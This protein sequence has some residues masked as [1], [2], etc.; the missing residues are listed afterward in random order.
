MAISTQILSLYYWLHVLIILLKRLLTWKLSF[1]QILSINLM[2]RKIC[3]TRVNMLDQFSSIC[4]T[5]WPIYVRS[6]GS[7]GTYMMLFW[8]SWIIKTLENVIFWLKIRHGANSNIRNCV[9][10]QHTLNMITCAAG[11][12]IYFKN[13]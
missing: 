1:Q 10:V 4:R 5:S 11:D 12:S 2:F 9:D 7:V 8:C 3:L 13:I 6:R